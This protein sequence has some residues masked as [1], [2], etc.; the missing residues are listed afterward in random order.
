MI[1]APNRAKYVLGNRV[2]HSR[3]DLPRALRERA[4]R[5]SRRQPDAGL[6]K[7]CSTAHA[8]IWVRDVKPSLLRMCST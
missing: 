5:H 7:P 4:E 6:C 8:A 1:F 3:P 2:P